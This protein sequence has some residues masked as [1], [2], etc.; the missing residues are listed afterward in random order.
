MHSQGVTQRRRRVG[1]EAEGF[2]K[3][4]MYVL[5]IASMWFSR[6]ATALFGDLEGTAR[7]MQMC[8]I[9]N[10]LGRGETRVSY[11]TSLPLSVEG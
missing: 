3:P 7:F 2:S 5:A 9:A 8:R 1:P 4:S 11:A 10:V 6:H